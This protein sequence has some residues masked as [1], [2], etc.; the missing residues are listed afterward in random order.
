MTE[1][2]LP[3]PASAQSGSPL[4]P[5]AFAI[6]GFTIAVLSL[7]GD[8]AWNY[9]VQ[10]MVNTSDFLD[11]DLDTSAI[12]LGVVQAVLAALGMLLGQRALAT[13]GESATARHLGGAALVVGG[14]GLIV[15]ALGIV[16]V[17]LP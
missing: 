17:L 9:P 13:A 11:R 16:V 6:A 15:A 7:F 5:T 14:L 3:A 1:P 4:T 12:S 2:S 8:G 10:V